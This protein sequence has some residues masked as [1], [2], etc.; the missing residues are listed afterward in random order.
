MVVT[1]EHRFHAYVTAATIMLMLAM[2]KFAVPL[3]EQYEPVVAL[4]GSAVALLLSFGIYK[5]LAVLLMDRFR[6]WMWVKRRLLGSSFVNGTWIGEFQTE[7]GARILTVEHFEQDLASLMI[8]GE[9]R[10]PN[11]TWYA[12]WHSV[13][14]AINQA[15]GRLNYVY[16]CRLATSRDSFDGICD[17]TFQRA[18]N[19]SAPTVLIGFS[20]D[21]PDGKRT[22]NK[23]R[24]Y[25]EQLV[26]Y[27]QVF[28]VHT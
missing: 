3:L 16:Q 6:S 24:R 14:T 10:Y 8:R 20:A 17:F 2:I 12:E 22:R 15:E 19:A 5:S 1:P 25:S 11:G 26:E 21:L 13:A 18:D 9:A 23:E 7:A 4:L 28:Q 27:D